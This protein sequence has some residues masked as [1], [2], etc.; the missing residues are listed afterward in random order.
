MCQVDEPALR[1]GLPLKKSLQ[2]DYLDWAVKAF[3]AATYCRPETQ[4][5]THFCYSEF[6]EPAII[7]AIIDMDPDVVTIENSRSNGDDSLLRS[8]IEGGF[9]RDLGPGVYDVHS[10][11][12]PSVEFIKGQMR[13]LYHSGLLTSPQSMW[14]NPDC[15]L[16]T[17]GYP[18]TLASLRNMVEAA[19]ELRVELFPSERDKVEIKESDHHSTP[20][21]CC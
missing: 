14:V 9:R 6:S 5:V 13:S 10:P 19:R 8:L 3:R 17:R 16:K 15:G 2:H 11:L 7:Q 21:R 4:M 18:E 12:V 1:E 20:H